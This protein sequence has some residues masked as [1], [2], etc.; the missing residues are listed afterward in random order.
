M[1]EGADGDSEDEMKE[2]LLEEGEPKDFE[3]ED[4]G[5]QVDLPPAEPVEFD[6]RDN[7]EIE[8]SLR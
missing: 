8:A 5:R 1:R 3:M 7:A 4:N 2:T 6:A